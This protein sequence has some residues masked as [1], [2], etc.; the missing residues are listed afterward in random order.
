M[1]KRTLLVLAGLWAAAA[2]TLSV[3]AG[4]TANLSWTLA[5]QDV[6]GTVVAPEAIVAT[7]ITWRRVGSTA[8]VGTI[9]VPTPALAKSIAGLSCG[10]FNFSAQTVVTGSVSDESPTV[11]YD[12]QITCKPNP[13]GGLAAH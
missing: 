9:D 2:V 3:A 13:P 12:T 1:L 10:Q 5:T 6:D 8:V 7:R 4:D 11:L